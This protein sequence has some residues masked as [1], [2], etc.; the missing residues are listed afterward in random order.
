MGILICIPCTVMSLSKFTTKRSAHPSPPSRPAIV[1]RYMIGDQVE[2]PSPEQMVPLDFGDVSSAFEK[3]DRGFLT[4]VTTTVFCVCCCRNVNHENSSVEII[5]DEGSQA[6]M[7]FPDNLCVFRLDGILFPLDEYTALGFNLG[8][9]VSD[10]R[11]CYEVFADGWNPAL[12]RNH[13]GIFPNAVDEQIHLKT[14][15]RLSDS[16]LGT[17]DRLNNF[18]P[19]LSRQYASL[20][21]SDN[22]FL[23]Y[24]Q[25][26]EASVYVGGS[27]KNPEVGQIICRYSEIGCDVL[28]VIV[29]VAEDY[30]ILRDSTDYATRRIKRPWGRDPDSYD[31]S[32]HYEEISCI[33][34][35]D[36]W[37]TASCKCVPM[38]PHLR[39]RD[40]R[41]WDHSELL[42]LSDGT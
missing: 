26:K 12:E 14:R 8:D 36:W 20:T 18:D 15:V 6:V 13:C 33:R 32:E 38:L 9:V 37:M 4:R 40:W 19:P 31:I 30:V 24:S 10:Y 29:Y 28:A 7:M 1:K 22:V 41:Q 25:T 21:Q 11:L 5:L 35:L 34:R 16:W 23:M 3:G 17:E 39:D 27:V 2:L 42:H